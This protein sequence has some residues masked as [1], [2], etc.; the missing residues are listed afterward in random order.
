MDL[1]PRWK[2]ALLPIS[3]A[4][5]VGSMLISYVHLAQGGLAVWSFDGIAFLL[6]PLV[7]IG[8]VLF[9][10]RKPRIGLVLAAIGSALAIFWVFGT[11][12]RDYRNSWIALNASWNDPDVPGY[13]GY[14]LLRIVSSAVSLT[15][16]IWAGTR[17][18]PSSWQI[19]GRP[20][21]QRIW[22]AIA[23]SLTSILAWFILFVSPYRQPI[24]VD[25][26][27]PDLGILHVQKDGLTFHETR[28]TIYHD[29]RFFVVRNNRK[30]FR[31][32]F[33]ERACEGLL[34]DRLREQ[35]KTVMGLPELKRT[36][37]KSPRALM[38]RA[39]E[40]WYTETGTY[41]IT[42]FTTENG[43]SPPKELVELF[44]MLEISP[45]EG[46]SRQYVVRDV[47]MGFCYDPK[48]GLGYTAENQRC[49]YGVDGRERCY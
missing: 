18:L 35:L 25:A 27:V 19:G 47:C 12:T 7:L 10:A 39:A 45:S 2:L 22:P 11:E 21:N 17:L 14:S 28:V 8:S 32:S 48:A 9:L 3:S 16:L 38:S 23:I 30:L 46:S 15:T 49:G 33:T 26:A 40:G 31:Y 29:S 34:D 44:R 43:V 1:K 41:A 13:I 20:A 24:I 6:S 37:D 5:F 36:Q 42:A 4:V